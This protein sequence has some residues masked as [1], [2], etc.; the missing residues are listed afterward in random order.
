MGVTHR[1]VM[2]TVEPLTTVYANNRV[3]I[4]HQPT[5]QQD[6]HSG[7]FSS[8]RQAQRFLTLPGLTQNHFRLG[9]PLLQAVNYRLWRTQAF[10]VWKES[11][12]AEVERETLFSCDRIPL[13][14]QCPCGCNLLRLFPGSI[15][16][17]VLTSLKTEIS[18]AL[19]SRMVD[20]V[21]PEMRIVAAFAGFRKSHRLLSRVIRRGRVHHWQANVQQGCPQRRFVI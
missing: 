10:Q 2:P 8:A 17:A 3:A 18:L 16:Q 4:S 7:G 11:V 14:G 5:R 1:E 15:L 20:R 9:R 6:S 12:G 21:T 19:S 13:N